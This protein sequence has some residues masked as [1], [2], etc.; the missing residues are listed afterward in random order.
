MT[1]LTAV[2][3][4]QMTTQVPM[5]AT[6]GI[7]FLSVTGHEA[8]L[9]LRDADLWRNHVGGP[10]VGA[11]FTLAETATGAL[12][13]ANM[14]DLLDVVTPLAKD[15]HMSLL[16]LARGNVTAT[17][18]F[19]EGGQGETGPRIRQQIEAGERPQCSIDVELRDGQRQTGAVRID[20]AFVPTPGSDGAGR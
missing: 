4:T 12:L 17:A 7:R 1:D 8:V 13:L 16:A 10:H 14:G 5:V 15:V 9:E 2:V 3:G 6:L 20:W 18:G 19:T 11:M